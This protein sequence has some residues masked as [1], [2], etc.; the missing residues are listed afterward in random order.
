MLTQICL[1]NKH[2]SNHVGETTEAGE[3][4]EGTK[5]KERIPMPVAMYSCKDQLIHSFSCVRNPPAPIFPSCIESMS[6]CFC[7]R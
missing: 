2:S 5:A 7:K 4:E 1:T 6:M 3:E